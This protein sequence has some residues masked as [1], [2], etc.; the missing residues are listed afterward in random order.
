MT[1]YKSIHDIPPITD[2]DIMRGKRTYMYFDKEPLF[3]FGHG[4]TYTEFTYKNLV[5]NSKNFK[6]NEEIKVSF[7]IENTG[8]MDSDEV[9]QVYVRALN[10]KVKRPN[11][12]LKG[13]TRVFIPKGEKRK[14][15]IT[16][17]VS[18]LFIWDVREEKYLVEKGEYEILIGSSS[19]DIKLRDKIYVEGEEIKNRNPFQKIKAFNFDDCYNVSFNTKGNFKETYVIFNDNNSYL[20][21]RDLGFYSKPKRLVMEISSNHSKIIL[22]FSKIDKEFSFEVLDTNNEWKEIVYLLDGNIEDIQ[23]LY[24]RGEK[25]LKI[26][27]FRFE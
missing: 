22:N 23:D 13:F 9:P 5:L 24:I 4:L 15:E 20:L 10:S 11:M 26:N 3:P 17:P 14:I 6:L 2:Y 18:D 21:F 19:K 16:I 8:D 1:W 25:G 12:Q 27:W 7:E